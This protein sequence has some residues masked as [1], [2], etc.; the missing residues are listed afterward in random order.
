VY[1]I[2][3][4][5]EK[6]KMLKTEDSKLERVSQKTSI[7]F[8]IPSEIKHQGFTA[9]ITLGGP[10][11]YTVQFFSPSNIFIDQH[12]LTEPISW[13]EAI[14]DIKATLECFSSHRDQSAA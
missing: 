2:G 9:R 6:R 7:S 14:T 8:E 3:P 13:P 1:G 12:T 4:A 5:E 10:G 11:F